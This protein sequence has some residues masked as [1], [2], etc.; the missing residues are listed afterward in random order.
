M[1]DPDSGL[2]ILWI[3]DN[4]LNNP[5]SQRPKTIICQ[6]LE[7]EL[8]SQHAGSRAATMLTV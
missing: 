3:Q 1:F 7:G 8:L 5:I 6:F 4:S 2:R